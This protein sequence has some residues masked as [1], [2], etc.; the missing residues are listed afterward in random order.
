MK[1]GTSLISRRSIPM[2]YRIAWLFLIMATLLGVPTAFAQTGSPE[3]ETVGKFRAACGQDV[4]RFCTGVQPGGGRILQCFQAHRD[5]LSR[6]CKL[7]FI[8]MGR[9]A[10]QE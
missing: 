8:E 1:N 9:R 3:G 2:A 4:R 7:L 10:A 6:S 5:E